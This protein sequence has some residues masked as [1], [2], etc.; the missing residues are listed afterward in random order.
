[1]ID[2][3]KISRL[4]YDL[5]KPL[6]KA[7]WTIVILCFVTAATFWFF[8]ALNKVYTTRIDYPIEL[9]FNHDS[10]VLVEEPPK[11][12]AINVTGGG[13]QL[14]K[15]TISLDSDPVYLQPENPVQTEYFSSGSLLPLFSSQLPDVNINYVATDTIFFKIEPYADRRLVIDM[16]SSDIGLK[17]NY[18]LTSS[19]R[20]EPDTVTF[21]GPQS[22]VQQLP[23][24]FMV[25]LPERNIDDRYD[26]E[27]SLDL[28]SPTIIKKNPELI[29]IRFDVEE[30]M[31][32]NFILD[33]EKVN[34]PPDSTIYL[35]ENQVETSFLLQRSYRNRIDKSDFLIIADLKYIHS[36][37][38]TI[39]LEIMDQPDYVKN[40]VLNKNRVKAIYAK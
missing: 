2:V 29:R 24:R 12:V 19:I 18:F 15:R 35:E 23:T 14:F 30:F 9:V 32:Q 40:V 22:L 39:T 34:F 38:S 21:H 5:S 8:N 36:V 26:E 11:E 31:P 6:K 3:T 20:I 4:I 16:D 27:L 28:F 7:N 1:M 25:S 17:E 10:L 37:D 33:I 13:W